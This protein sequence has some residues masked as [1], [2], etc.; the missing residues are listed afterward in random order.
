LNATS[1]KDIGIYPMT[2]TLTDDAKTDAGFTNV[3]WFGNVTY[4]FNLRVLKKP[5][6]VV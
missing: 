6:L 5:L 1:D 2:I 4:S 3:S